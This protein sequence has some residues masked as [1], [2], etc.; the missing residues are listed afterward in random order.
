[1]SAMVENLIEELE[2]EAFERD[3]YEE[4]FYALVEMLPEVDSRALLDSVRENVRL[5]N[6]REDEDFARGMEEYKYLMENG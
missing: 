4:A 1:M 3:V 2:S 6:E 5:R